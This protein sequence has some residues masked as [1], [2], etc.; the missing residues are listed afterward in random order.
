[1]L[2]TI[3][4]GPR[5]LLLCVCYW[6]VKSQLVSWEKA[7]LWCSHADLSVRTLV[8]LLLTLKEPFDVQSQ[9]SCHRVKHVLHIQ[10][11][12]VFNYCRNL[13]E[14]PPLTYFFCCLSVNWR[15]LLRVPV[16]L[17]QNTE[18]TWKARECQQQM[19]SKNSFVT[20]PRSFCS[21]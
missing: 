18:K 2:L 3:T 11:L 21:N 9:F 8:L 1:M 15:Y 10:Q 4:N 20:H 16:P 7:G 17:F 13:C 14:F 6:T 5:F 19:F 12:V